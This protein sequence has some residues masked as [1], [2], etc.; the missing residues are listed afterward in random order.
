MRNA[1]PTAI[2]V[3]SIS[4]A[5]GCAFAPQAVKL[6]PVVKVEQSTVGA[7]Q[8]V[9][10]NVVDE[11]PKSTLG[12]RGAGG[13]GAELTLEGDL[14]EIVQRS[15]REGLRRQGFIAS[16]EKAGQGRELR[17]EI[18]S[19]DYGVTTGF[20][21]GDLR[22][23]CSLKGI[24]IHGSERPYEK[25]HRG[26]FKENVQVVQGEDANNVYVNNALSEAINN[27]LSDE[28]L[29]GCLAGR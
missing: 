4:L 3:L 26:E 8:A 21:S 16:A 5:S 24:C 25:L 11:R 10:V 6:D 14:A 19:L 13:V 15:I 17:V 28:Q 18:R 22:T 2:A 23:Q 7:D 1:L 27:L 12:T 9:R 29:I 20:W